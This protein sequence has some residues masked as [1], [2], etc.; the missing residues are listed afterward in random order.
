M[1]TLEM[2]RDWREGQNR[3]QERQ[4]LSSALVAAGLIRM[5]EDYFGTCTTA[6]DSQE[7]EDA[8][9]LVS[10]PLRPAAEAAGPLQIIG[11]TSE[12]LGPSGQVSGAG[13][14]TPGPAK[15]APGAEKYVG[16]VPEAT[17]QVTEQEIRAA[18]TSSTVMDYQDDALASGKFGEHGGELS[19]KSYGFRLIIPKGALEKDEQIGLRVLTEIPDGLRLQEDEMFVSHGFKL[20]PTGLQFKRRVKLIIPHCAV[21]DIPNKIE[22]V[23]YSWNQS[24]TFERISYS[25]NMICSVQDKWLEVLISH[26]CGG[27]FAIIWS[28]I[29]S[30]FRG[31]LLSCMSFLPRTLPSS[32]R[33]VLEVRFAKKIRGQTWKNI[34]ALDVRFHPVK[35]DDDEI[36]FRRKK[37]TVSCSLSGNSIN[38][39]AIHYEDI[40]SHLKKTVYFALDLSNNH[41]ETLVTL[42]LDQDKDSDRRETIKFNTHFQDETEDAVRS[43]SQP[44]RPAAKAAGPLQIPGSASEA[45]GPALRPS[46]PVYGAEGSTPGPARPA[47]RAEQYVGPV[48]EATWQVTEQEIGA[49]GP[50]HGQTRSAVEETREGSKSTKIILLDIHLLTLAKRFPY[51]LYEDL[52]LELG[53]TAIGAENRLVK[54]SQDYKRAVQ[55]V[56]MNWK[57]RTGG[58]KADLEN[59]LKNIEAS[60]LVGLLK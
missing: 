17:S 19:V 29:N 18:G 55:E 33:P 12:A 35:S 13:G 23:L 15:P 41:D 56:L 32:R 57:T 14:S 25:A 46:G 37:I 6:M 2:L 22:T 52:C 45:T 34:H 47:P 11:S 10:Q 49:A 39:E 43:V 8:L 42:K 48:P 16:H 4:V 21:V 36:I 1:G 50:T 27:R 26:F 40:Q 51:S 7:T 28:W 44:S 59:V 38:P 58:Y 9:R 53:D 24:G 3:S 60:G 54:Y 20:W 31:I 30:P 5:N